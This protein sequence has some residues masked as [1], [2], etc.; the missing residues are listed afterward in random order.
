MWKSG[1]RRETAE[2]LTINRQRLLSLSRAFRVLVRLRR[3]RR[4]GRRAW[5][6]VSGTD[7]KLLF[8]HLS[9]RRPR[10]LPVSAKSVRGHRPR[11]G[12]QAQN[13]PEFIL[14][15]RKILSYV[16]LLFSDFSLS[17]CFATAVCL[18]FQCPGLKAVRNRIGEVI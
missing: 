10:R 8:G 17:N 4:R 2:R 5:A 11:C 14:F 3:R 9:D 12:L 1:E 7:V 18:R 6:W 13:H 15:S 16:S